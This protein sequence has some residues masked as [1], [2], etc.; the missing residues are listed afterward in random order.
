MLPKGGAAVWGNRTHAPDDPPLLVEGEE[1]GADGS[2]LPVLEDGAFVAPSPDRAGA[3]PRE[4]EEAPGELPGPSSSPSLAEEGGP[5]ADNKDGGV[6]VTPGERRAEPVRYGQV[7]GFA[8]APP[9]QQG[10]AESAPPPKEESWTVGDV[11]DHLRSDPDD[12]HLRRRLTEDYDFGCACVF[13][14]SSLVGCVVSVYLCVYVSSPRVPGRS[15]PPAHTPF[16]PFPSPPPNNNAQTWPTP[17]SSR[18][19]R[20]RTGGSGRTLWRWRC[21]RRPR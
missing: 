3:W 10:A 4:G 12:P 8:P 15:P 13:S 2:C 5:K 17:A 19:G 20:R 18:H 9:P 11:L 21:P 14:S 16:F 6:C 1:A 7:I